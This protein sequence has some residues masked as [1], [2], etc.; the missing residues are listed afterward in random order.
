MLLVVVQ[1]DAG[2]WPEEQEEQ[3]VHTVELE[4]FV[5]VLPAVHT[6]HTEALALE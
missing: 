1:A 3:E 5:Y 6:V 4:E 2:Y